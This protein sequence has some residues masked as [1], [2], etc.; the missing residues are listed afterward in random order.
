MSGETEVGSIEW[1]D[2][3]KAELSRES[4]TAKCS[5]EVVK[6]NHLN[7]TQQTF[8]TKFYFTLILPADKFSH[9]GQ[10]P[11]FDPMISFENGFKDL[12]S[13]AHIFLKF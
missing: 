5:V 4:L 1:W 8:F 11:R 2:W 7:Y 3:W 12:V 9:D 13:R 6:L 10:T